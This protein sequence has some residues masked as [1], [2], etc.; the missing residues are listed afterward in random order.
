[1]PPMT[2]RFTNGPKPF[3]W[4]YSRLKNFESC[5][6]RH[7]HIDIAK[8]VQEEESDELHWGNFLH[9][10]LAKRLTKGVAL[11][12]TAKQYQTWVDRVL[13][14]PGNIVAEQKLAITADF[15]ATGYFAKDVWFRSVA[16]VIKLNGRVALL[17]DW[18]TGKIIE[19]SQQLALG[20]ACVFAHY[21]EVLAV[22][23]E[24]F[25]LKED[26]Q[27]SQTF[28]R[29]EMPDMWA[30]ILPRVKALQHAHETTSYPARPGRLCKR[31][32]PVRQCP[33]CG[34]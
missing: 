31:W 32:C 21:P 11:P 15:G 33:H 27:T 26:A 28:R 5:P 3:T 17:G 18:K 9:D 16:D 30:A 12:D 34:E 20:A 24:F 1:M 2:T 10:A 23:S 19:D 4:S 7:W 13:T 8:D 25:W 6:K 22:R 29:A 14:G